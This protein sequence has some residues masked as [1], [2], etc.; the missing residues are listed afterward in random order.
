MF[1]KKKKKSI[2]ANDKVWINKTAKFR[3]LYTT[4]AATQQSKEALLVVNHFTNTQNEVKLL[5][6]QLNIIHQVIEYSN[7]NIA[8]ASIYITSA[9]HLQQATF[10]HPLIQHLAQRA[11]LQVIISEHHPAYTQDQELLDQL[12]TLLPNAQPCFFT[13]LD[14][15]FM[16]EFGGEKLITMMQRLGLN[17]NETLEH[18]MITKSIIRAQQKLEK[19]AGQNIKA[20]SQQEWLKQSGVGS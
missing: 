19:K 14:E 15:P 16:Q 4:F 11:N 6:E 20:N 5:A 2:Q 7:E 1:F 8:T 18:S 10:S 17:E 9:P 3:G 13:S 12:L